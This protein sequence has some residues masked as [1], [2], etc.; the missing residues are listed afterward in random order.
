MN[1]IDRASPNHDARPADTSVD[2]MIIHYTGMLSFEDAL[3]R[4]SDPAAKVSAHYA[5]GRDG[6][7]YQMVD[8]DRRAWHAGVSSWR[9]HTDI[10][11]RSIG[12]ELENKGHEY[13]Y[14]DFT[15]PQMA[16]LIQLCQGILA[17][18]SIPSRNVVSHSDVAP[19]RKKDP[20]EKFDWPRLA[21]AGIGLWPDPASGE[22]ELTLSEFSSGLK[23]FGYDLTN[24]AAA[25]RAF[26]RHFRPMDVDG[27]VNNASV[28]AL[29][30][31]L[32][33]SE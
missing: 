1:L 30:S 24:E 4:L 18:H 3:D 21:A 17:R 28:A 2:I 23:K 8:E 20:G 12:I 33:V 7:I 25:F 29:D 14:E 5:I 11:G 32:R 10:N 15:D 22:I 16:N 13:G 31:L 26:H 6:A 9:G 27:P 19:I